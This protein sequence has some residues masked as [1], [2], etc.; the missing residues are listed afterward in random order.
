LL[1]AG[2]TLLFNLRPERN[3]A[4]C[5]GWF[6][7]LIGSITSARISAKQHSPA[8]VILLVAKYN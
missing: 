6:I 7:V 4:Q 2:E 8:G 3:D 1:L 5:L